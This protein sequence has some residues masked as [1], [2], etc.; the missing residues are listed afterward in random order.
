MAIYINMNDKAANKFKMVQIEDRLRFNKLL[1]ENKNIVPCSL[2]VNKDNG[3]IY[4]IE[5]QTGPVLD[6]CMRYDE[7]T[8][9]NNDICLHIGSYLDI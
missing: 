7:D 1:E 3:T 2:Y 9:I 8:T 4:F 6:L 5:E